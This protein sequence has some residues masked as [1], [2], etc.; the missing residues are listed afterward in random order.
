ML[1]AVLA[2]TKLIS[3]CIE[4]TLGEILRAQRIGMSEGFCENQSQAETL[5]FSEAITPPSGCKWDC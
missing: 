1:S 5:G 3:E 2:N 4:N